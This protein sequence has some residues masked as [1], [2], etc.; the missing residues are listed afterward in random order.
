MHT[1]HLQNVRPSWVL[2]G[3]FVSVAVISLFGLVLAAAGLVD[4]EA[5]GVGGVWGVIAVATGFFTGGLVTGARVGAAPILH[6]VAMAVV[7]LLV[8]FVANLSFGEALDAT[9]WSDGE[10]AFYAGSLILQMVAAA[11]GARFGSRQ[12]RR[13]TAAS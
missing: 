4:P 8:W 9:T 11:L 2:F 5:S 12:Q 3:W 6:G 1:E 13:A 10:P 7:S